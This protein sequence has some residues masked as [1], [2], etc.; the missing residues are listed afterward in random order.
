MV[1]P[2]LNCMIHMVFLLTLQKNMQKKGFTIDITGFNNEL[3]LQRKRARAAREDVDSMQSQNA[4]L[5]NITDKSV[6]VVM[7]I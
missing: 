7:K 1:K 4:T 6:F 5:M 3:E 2:H